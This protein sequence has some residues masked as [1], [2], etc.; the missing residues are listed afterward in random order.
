VAKDSGSYE[1]LKEL[2]ETASQKKHN[3]SQL[4]AA[5]NEKIQASVKKHKRNELGRDE[6]AH[7]IQ[8]EVCKLVKGVTQH[9]ILSILS[10]YA[11]HQHIMASSSS[12]VEITSPYPIRTQRPPEL[13]LQDAVTQWLNKVHDGVEDEFAG[14]YGPLWGYN[15][16]VGMLPHIGFYPVIYTVYMLYIC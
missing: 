8:T 12:D 11:G 4:S 5:S 13:H 1:E 3:F 9:L 7:N 15:I 2:I 14:P 10:V 16:P 6:H